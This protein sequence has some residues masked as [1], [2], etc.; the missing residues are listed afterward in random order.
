MRKWQIYAVVPGT[1]IIRC[2]GKMMMKERRQMNKYEE[3][4]TERGKDGRQQ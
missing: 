3:M 1:T 4:M 2:K